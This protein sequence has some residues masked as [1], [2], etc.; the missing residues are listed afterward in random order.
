MTHRHAKMDS[1]KSGFTLVE[2]LVSITILLMVIITPMTI[3][4]R[5]IQSAYHAG[6]QLAATHLAQEGVEV[7]LRMRDDQAL[8]AFADYY[9]D[10]NP[11]VD[12]NDWYGDLGAACRDTDPLDTEGCDIELENSSG[13]LNRV[14]GYKDCT[15]A[16]ACRLEIYM[17]NDNSIKRLY[18]YGDTDWETS[19]FTR[20]LKVIDHSGGIGEGPFQ[21][22]S[23]VSWYST[24]FREDRVVTIESWIYDHYNRF[25]I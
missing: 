6:D 22:I 24:V 14:A 4:S 7:V 10:S 20:V 3:V 25:S 8:E 12:T 17:G 5:S 13:D 2:T 1:H 16:S 21:I 15:N 23:T 19:Q 11:D 9:P 18:G